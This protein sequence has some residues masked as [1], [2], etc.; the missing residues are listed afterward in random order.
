MLPACLVFLIFLNA[1]WLSMVKHLKNLAQLL[2]GLQRA[3]RLTAI[4]GKTHSRIHFLA[5]P[6]SLVLNALR[7]SEVKHL[8]NT[9]S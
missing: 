3:Q 4:R 7:Q 6:R 2:A 5:S 8:L 1:L 9:V